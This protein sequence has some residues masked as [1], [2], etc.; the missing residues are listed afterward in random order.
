MFSAFSARLLARLGAAAAPRVL[1]TSIPVSRFPI[2]LARRTFLTSPRLAYAAAVRPPKTAAAAAKPTPKKKVAKKTAPAKKVAPK[3]KVAVKKKP[4]TKK[5]A[6]P[7]KKA[8]AKKAVAKPV[9]RVRKKAAPRNFRAA[10][11]FYSKEFGKVHPDLPVLE[12]AKAAGL[13]WRA[14]SDE[15]KVPYHAQAA[16]AKVA[17][18]PA[19][20]K[21]FATVDP[22]VLRRLNLKR[23]AAKLPR[24]RA[25]APSLPSSAPCQPSSQRREPGSS[26]PVVEQVK[27]RAAEWHA[28]PES[29]KEVYKRRYKE[30]LDQWRVEMTQKD[31]QV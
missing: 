5:K 27:L 30:Q 24:I 11:I 15:E 14:L 12:R 3:K 25:P 19:R 21:Y 29:E 20:E 17:A 1:P 28:L 7:K 2:S 8:V 4:A 26:M 23:K 18:Q 31:P 16:A 10:F 22:S 13:A 9:R 6:A